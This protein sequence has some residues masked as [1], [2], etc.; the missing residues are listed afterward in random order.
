[1]IFIHPI[2]MTVTART[3]VGEPATGA[4]SGFV[5][6]VRSADTG[7]RGVSSGDTG[8]GGTGVRFRDDG[9][10]GTQRPVTVREGL[11]ALDRAVQLRAEHVPA[12]TEAVGTPADAPGLLAV[13]EAGLLELGDHLAGLLPAATPLLGELRGVGVDDEA[14]PVVAG[15]ADQGEQRR[16]QLDAQAGLPQ[17][18]GTC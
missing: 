16:E 18:V 17:L 13:E 6:G 8:G 9:R 5:P 12:A 14:V 10:R 1:M 3:G 7:G 15:H 4:S 11:P 2:L